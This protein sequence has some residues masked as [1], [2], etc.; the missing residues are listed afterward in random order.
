M[1]ATANDP[2]G[3]SSAPSGALAS[4]VDTGVPVISGMP[5]D[6]TV[7][8]D[9]GLDTAVVNLTAPTANDTKDGPLTPVQTRGLASGS[10]FPIGTT[11][12]TYTATDSAG[13]ASSES[14]TVTV[15]KKK[16]PWVILLPALVAPK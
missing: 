6:T 13:N 12:V 1:T 10:A 9:T 5:S 14:F 16:F 4:T 2:A 3:N 7:D 11:T 8:T 15:V